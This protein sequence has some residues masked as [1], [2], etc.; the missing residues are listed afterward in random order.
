MFK[1][2]QTRMLVCDMAGTVIHEKGIVYNALF[3]TIKLINSSIERREI[4]NFYG[5]NKKEVIDYFVDKQVMNDPEIVKMNLNS[6]FNYFLKKE[7][8]DNPNVKLVDSNI[9]FFFNALR[10]QDIKVTLNTGY[11]RDIQNLLIDKFNL[12]D[13]IDDYISSEEVSR[14]R[15]YPYMI[16]TLM[17]RNKIEDPTS[18]IKIGDTV[19]DIIEGKNANCNT[20]GVLSGASSKSILHKYNPDYIIDSIIDLKIN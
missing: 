20:V 19:A 14:G 10:D 1:L 9:P 12:L 4:N 16:N 11:N 7:Y 3:N 2:S 15:P 5:C 17:K 8:K 13:H 18:V 6:E